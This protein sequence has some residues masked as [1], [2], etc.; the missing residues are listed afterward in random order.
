M[1]QSKPQGER[2]SS[3]WKKSALAMAMLAA[4]VDGGVA[5]HLATGGS[6]PAFVTASPI[7]GILSSIWGPFKLCSFM[8]HTNCVISGDTIRYQ[9]ETLRMLDYDTPRVSGYRCGSEAMRGFR[10]KY[11]LLGLLNSGQVDI[12]IAGAREVDGY[13]R[14]LRMVTVNGTSVGDTL[15]LEGLASRRDGGRHDWC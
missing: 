3:L 4:A 14:K 2:S 6:M 1:T 13:G 10:A 5:T 12:T 15:V 11:R 7:A 9:G 8:A